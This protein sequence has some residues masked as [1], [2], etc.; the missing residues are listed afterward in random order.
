[1][2]YYINQNSNGVALPSKNKADYL[3]LDG[4]VEINPPKTF[5]PGLICV[6][7][8]STFDA[9]LFCYKKE[10]MEMALNSE[11]FRPKIWLIHPKAAELAGYK[12]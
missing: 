2:G 12:S 9:A 6:I 5:V 1:M 10:E 3:L 11:D 8:N 7:E 4:A